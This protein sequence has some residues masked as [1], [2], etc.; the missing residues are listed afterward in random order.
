MSDDDAWFEPKLY[1]IGAGLPVRWQGWALVAAYC[2]AALG[3]ALALG[4]HRTLLFI[5]LAVLSAAMIAITA[6]HT[7]GGWRWR[8]GN[9]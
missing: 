8:W 3:A 7:R 9:Y 4:R 1:G 6:Q 5:V 2:A